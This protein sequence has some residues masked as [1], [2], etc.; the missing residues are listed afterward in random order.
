MLV[1]LLPRAI[2]ALRGTAAAAEC[3]QPQLTEI[4]QCSDSAAT[5]R[6]LLHDS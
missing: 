1:L 5:C 3:H 6:G 2:R 4:V